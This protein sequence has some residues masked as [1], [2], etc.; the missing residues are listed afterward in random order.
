MF[1][2]S[3]RFENLYT[4]IENVHDQFPKLQKV[5]KHRELPIKHFSNEKIG[6]N[7]FWSKSKYILNLHVSDLK[8]ENKISLKIDF[9]K[10]IFFSNLKKKNI[11]SE[12]VQRVCSIHYLIRLSEMRTTQTFIETTC[13]NFISLSKVNECKYRLYLFSK[14][15]T[16]FNM[17]WN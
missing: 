4:Q 3:D 17:K 12:S 9:V 1:H 10:S 2:S 6:K 15:V 13:I 8:K 14:H 16:S 11:S 7:C 5:M